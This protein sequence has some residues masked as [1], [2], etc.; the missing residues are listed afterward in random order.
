MNHLLNLYARNAQVSQR[1]FTVR[2]LADDEAEI[3]L[4]DVIVSDELEAEWWGGI[5]PVAVRKALADLSDAVKTIHLRI[6]SPGGSTF[7]ASAIKQSLI[8]HPA[9]VVAHIDGIAA[10]AATHV[11]LAGEEIVIAESAMIMIHKA[12]AYTAGNA[13]ELRG[14]AALLDKADEIQLSGYVARTKQSEQQ[15]RDWMAAETWFNAQEAVRFGFADRAT[16]QQIDAKAEWDLSVYS[17]APKALQRV[18]TPAKPPTAPAKPEPPA[19]DRAA[20][21]RQL[22]ALTAA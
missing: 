17:R 2:A 15:L 16:S 18:Q 10:S 20:C 3:L 13:D 1:A 4:Y 11:M 21:L 9:R 7:A 5:S 8:E 22:D 12:W 19:F 6:N 14:A